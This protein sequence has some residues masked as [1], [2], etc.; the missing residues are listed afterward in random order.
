[1]DGIFSVD[2]AGGVETGAIREITSPST[3]YVAATEPPIVII[4]ITER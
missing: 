4:L 2:R 3:A 1:M